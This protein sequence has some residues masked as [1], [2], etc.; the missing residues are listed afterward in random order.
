M[1]AGDQ[2][3]R[4]GITTSGRTVSVGSSDLVQ[5][6][7]AIATQPRPLCYTP[8]NLNDRLKVRVIVWVSCAIAIMQVAFSARRCGDGYHPGSA[9]GEKELAKFRILYWQ[10]IPSVVEATDDKGSKHKEQL[11]ARFQEL[12]DSIAMRKK[13]VGT[14]AYLEG[15]RRSRP[16]KR[17]GDAIDVAKAVA[18]E[19]ESAFDEIARTAREA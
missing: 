3:Y 6:R 14:D 13:M 5:R 9:S 16:E 7:L 18:S 4:G 2:G 19:L 8:A 1:G 15:W 12:I 17:D 10:Q 11:S